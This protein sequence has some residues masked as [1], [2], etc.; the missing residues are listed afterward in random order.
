MMTIILVVTVVA[1]FGALLTAGLCVAAA[2][3]DRLSER[4]RSDPGINPLSDEERNAFT[5][6][7]ERFE[8]DE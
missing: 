3:A 2:R 7:T 1:A 8:E 4:H 5:D 6:L